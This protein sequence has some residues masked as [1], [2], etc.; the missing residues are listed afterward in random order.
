MIKIEIDTD[1]VSCCVSG[2]GGKIIKEIGAAV[3]SISKAFLQSMPESVRQRAS[4]E[5]IS[6]CL[7]GVA[8]ATEKCDKCETGD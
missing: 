8:S 3:Y 2:K 7:A 1:H 5:I 4:R 6:A